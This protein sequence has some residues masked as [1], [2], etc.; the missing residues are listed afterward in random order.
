MFLKY[1]SALVIGLFLAAP[2]AHAEGPVFKSGVTP[3]TVPLTPG[4]NVDL[5]TLLSS[6][7]TGPIKWEAAPTKPAWVTVDSPN[8]KMTG[9]PTAADV[10]LH[11]FNLTASFGEFASIT[12]IDLTV[13]APP[14]WT[15]P[16]I[17][18]GIQNEGKSMT[19]FDLKK[20]VTNPAGGT[21]SFTATGLPKWMTLT[22][23]G[24]I[25]GTPQR[26]DVGNY[27]GIVFTVASN[28]GSSTANGSGTVLITIHPPSWISNPITLNNA[29]EDASYS[30]NV[31]Q[32]ILDFEKSSFSYSEVSGSPWIQV[33]P[34]GTIFGTPGKA[35]IGPATVTVAYSTTI[36]GTVYTAATTFNFNVIHVNHPP[37]WVSNPLPLPDGATTVA[38]TQDVSKSATDP[39]TGDKLTFSISGAPAWVKM[40][41]TGVISGT[42]TADGPVTFVA[43]VTDSSNAS[44]STTI[45][46]NVVHTNAPP[47][48]VP[49]P[50]VLADGKEDITYVADL[51]SYVK[52]P[53][54]LPLTFTQLGGPAWATVS[55]N[56]IF[57]G[58]PKSGDVG[59]NK[60]SVTVANSVGSDVTDVLINIIHTNH[61]PFWVLN[62]IHLMGPEETPMSVDISGYAKDPDKTDK[63]TFAL[64]NG[65]SWG[66]LSAAGVFS[67]TPPVSVE[68]ENTFAIRVSDQGNLAADGVLIVTVTHVNHP[69]YW[70]QDPITLLPDAKERS[71]YTNSVKIYAADPDVNDTLTFSKIPGSGADWLTVGSDGTVSGTPQRANVGLNTFKVRVMDPANAFADVTVNVTVDK[72][73]LPPRWRQD[74]IL[75]SDAHEDVSYH[76]DLTTYAV[77]DDGNPITFSLVS[78]PT[79]MQVSATGQ[80]TGT[81]AKADIGAFSAI[82]RVTDNGGLFADTH[83]TG[84]VIHTPHPP[85]IGTIPPI[86]VKER[87]I[88]KWALAQYVT[89]PDGGTLNFATVDNLDWLT[90][91]NTGDITLKPAFKDIAHYTYHFKVDNGQLTTN[92]T[93]D[94]TVVRDPRAPIWLQDPIKLQA[95]SNQP[96]SD[97]L[98]GRAK[99]LDGIRL[100]YKLDPGGKPW[101][102]L[103]PATGDLSGTPGSTDLGDNSFKV[104]A[105]NDQ[106]CALATLVITVVPGTQIDTVTIDAP[107][108]GAGTEMLWNIDTSNMCSQLLQSLKTNI[109]VF[110]AALDKAQIHHAGV[111]LSSDAHKWDGLPI[112]NNNGPILMKWSDTNVASD[113]VSRMSASTFGDDG[114]CSNC[115]SSPIWS[116]FR[117]L[118]RVPSLTEIYHNGYIASN[119]PMEEMIITQQTDHFPTFAKNTPQSTWAAGDY[120]NNFINFNK[121]EKKP[122][123]ISV[124]A[125]ECPSLIEQEAAT[126]APVNSYQTL[127]DKTAGQYYK[128][129]DCSFNLTTILNDYASKVITKAYINA[130]SSIKLS[131]V[132]LSAS[133]IQVT[134]GGTVLQ[135][136]TGAASDLWSYDSTTN[137]ILVNWYL[138]DQTTLTPGE[139]IRIQYRI[140]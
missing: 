124:I 125:P 9:Q 80:I 66:T 112:T 109:K 37:H 62:P 137:S 2:A 39:D 100:S 8:H 133:S 91:F 16:N 59:L 57:S 118:Q 43:T 140:S 84:T 55:A 24:I 36:N 48:W 107:V 49:K 35:N 117:F 132:P 73:S 42:P 127:V 47:T 123:R 19:A 131:A 136:N 58:T 29:T 113:F 130:H 41:P 77:D 1:F 95:K 94:I 126:A 65:P 114:K 72:V 14:T 83:G 70:T 28:T 31:Y 38:Y 102:K 88:T 96:F 4:M 21:L 92:G 138:I 22:T 139:T 106:L 103:D 79:W 17:D 85:V 97:S 75:L 40:S 81:P 68:G 15:Q 5:L 61:S 134:L 67:G 52:N 90:M 99:D 129:T 116:T 7:G 10:G 44:D 128:I 11:S 25:T 20:Y 86:V 104:E 23:D 105:C 54:G 120:A 51:N 93:V 3:I 110:F 34:S 12:R 101:L 50:V 76:F 13:V 56:G 71:A 46:F 135:G 119:V 45:K 89:N 26:P 32:Y 6:Q 82:F 74:P 53:D 111:Y 18:L 27:S 87:S 78:G 108:P 64:V 69:P 115:F 98:S 60:F 63:L 30:V 33:S 122:L 121:A